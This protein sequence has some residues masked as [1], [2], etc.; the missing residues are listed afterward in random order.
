MSAKKSQPSERPVTNYRVVAT[1]KR[2]VRPLAG[3]KR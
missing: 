2:P 1:A 3:R